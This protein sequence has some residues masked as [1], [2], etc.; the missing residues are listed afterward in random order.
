MTVDAQIGVEL[1]LEGFTEASGVEHSFLNVPLFNDSSIF[2]FPPLCI[3]FGSVTGVCLYTPQSP[4]DAAYEASEDTG[5]VDKRSELMPRAPDK[6]R[7]PYWI[8]CD[9]AK[10]EIRVQEYP[11]PNAIKKPNSKYDVPIMKPGIEQCQEHPSC[12]EA[13]WTVTRGSKADLSTG[14]WASK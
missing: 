3:P 4:H 13:D 10:T 2:T 6:K 11:K 8:T 14:N 1:V 9:T 12:P 7:R 5:G